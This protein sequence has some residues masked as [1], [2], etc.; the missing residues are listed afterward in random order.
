MKLPLKWLKDYTDIDVSPREY[1]HAL[2]MSGSKVEGLEVLGSEIDRVVVGKILTVEKHPDADRLQ[3]C[4]VD[5]GSGTIQIVTG[6]TN[7]K[8]NDLVPVALDGSSLPGGIRIKKGKLRG[9]ESAGMMCSI[10]ELGLTK[11]DY[12]NAAE[13]GIFI[14]EGDPVPGT[15][16]KEYLGM[17]DTVVEFEITSNRPDCFSIIG[18]ARESAAT[19]GTS[20]R[21]PE[22]AVKE[23]GEPIDGKVSVEIKAPDLCARYAARIV[24][25]VKIGPSP[26]WMQ[27]RLRASGIRPINN[28]VDITN[29]VM[30]EY[31]QP[32]HAFDLRNLKG[33]RI[34]V[35]RAENGEIMRTLDG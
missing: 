16:I 2:T 15:D 27:Q 26:R 23:L 29:Y 4:Q 1:A 35:R 20:F 14:L 25:N 7:I 6:A 12:P 19:F 9:V 30:L 33:R 28:I 13:D 8:V 17:N 11:D 3:V 32:M 18:L 22:V 5:V 24:E 21:I 34:I 31:G 10:A